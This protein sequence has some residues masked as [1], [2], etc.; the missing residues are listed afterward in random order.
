MPKFNYKIETPYIESFRSAKIAGLFDLP[1]QEKL[2][3][4]WNVDLPIEELNDDWNIGLIVGASGAGKTILSKKIFGEENY[5]NGFQWGKTSFLD[6]FPKELDIND[7][8]NALSH[9]GF[10]SPP[11]WLLPFDK[12]SNGQ[13]FR[14]EMAR[15]LMS[16]NQ[17]TIV[18]EFTSVVDRNVAQIG[19]A[20]IQKNIRKNK[21][22]IVAVS[23]HY[24]II[25]WLQP[26]W[27]YDVG[28]NQYFRGCLQRPQIQLEIYKCSR[29]LWQMFKSHH[30]LSGVLS[31]SA[32]CFVALI[33]DNPC[34]FSSY[35]HFQHPHLKNTKREHRTVVL[36]DYQGIGI[37]NILS[38]FVGQYCLDQGFGYQSVTSHPAMIFHRMK[39][40]NWIMY[41]APKIL[42]KCNNNYKNKFQSAYNRI[43]A[44]FKFIGNSKKPC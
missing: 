32:Q 4:E 11:S 19:C 43:T 24:D 27:Y 15:I 37:G 23:C 2:Y 14:A 44:S 36:P 22:K 38:N 41:S 17:L 26:D 40:P 7:I 39:S 12:L 6:D 28:S 42:G 18:D 29:S 3:K 1:P 10:S 31:N 25:E 13:K 5:H 33:N 35:I 34:A 9:V 8:V 16:K 21:K 30:Y 20:A